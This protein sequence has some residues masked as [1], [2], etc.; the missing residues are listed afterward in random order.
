[1]ADWFEHVRTINNFFQEQSHLI[2]FLFV[3]VHRMF[4]EKQNK[5]SKNEESFI[6]VMMHN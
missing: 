1:M 5:I 2:S 4:I 3:F 6:Y